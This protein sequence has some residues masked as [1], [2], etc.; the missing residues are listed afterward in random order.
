MYGPVCMVVWEGEGCEAFPYPDSNNIITLRISAEITDKEYKKISNV[1][2][3]QISKFGK[4]RVFL[5][6][7][8]YPSLNSFC[9]KTEKVLWNQ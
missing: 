6:V 4:I 5:V 2:D 8:H 9:R 3:N 7:D 1:F